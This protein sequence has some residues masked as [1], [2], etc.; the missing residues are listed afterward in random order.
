M[1]ITEI[2]S[3]DEARQGFYPTPPEVVAKLLEDIDWYK[4]EN[5]LEPSAGKGNIVDGVEVVRCKDC[6]YFYYDTAK[7][8]ACELPCGM[9]APKENGSCYYGERKD[10]G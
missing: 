3:T 5:V 10:N 4:I 6:K 2:I 8:P 9:V 1:S 7:E